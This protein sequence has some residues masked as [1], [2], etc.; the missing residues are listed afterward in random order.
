MTRSTRPQ[1]SDGDLA[2][3]LHTARRAVGSDD[4]VQRVH[5]GLL[6]KLANGYAP[7]SAAAA[8]R[9]LNP[10]LSSWLG[11]G[12]GALLLAAAGGALWSAATASTPM[13]RS[14]PAGTAEA[15]MAGRAS[16]RPLTSQRREPQ[17]GGPP[18][19]PHVDATEPTP[20]RPEP[21]QPNAAGRRDN[22]QP[23]AN[24]ARHAAR[25]AAGKAPRAHG[26]A[27][28]LTRDNA[29][30]AAP[31]ACSDADAEVS[32]LS[33]AQRALAAQPKAALALLNEHEQRFS[34]G[35]LSQER[36]ILRID[37][38]RALGLDAVAAEHA[39]A[40]IARYP[41]SR[42]AHVL[43]RWIAGETERAADHKK[44]PEGLPTP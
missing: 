43:R 13:A 40:L 44:Q 18:A 34:C 16:N 4:A 24:P 26:R 11:K 38:E 32:M 41:E 12:L 35:V 25:T 19:A 6:D 36:D 9:R 2:Q 33:R 37:A 10:K 27:P 15:T 21:T 30:P 7:P 20:G 28:H 3:A 31:A 42:E 23:S 17:P 1:R 39:R 14:K 22:E 5:A 29:R 8:T